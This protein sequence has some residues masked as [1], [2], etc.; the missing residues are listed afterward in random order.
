MNILIVESRYFPAVADA[1]L[2]RATL[3]LEKGGARFERFS[4]PGVLELPAAIAAAA[5][6][7]RTFEGYVALG[8]VLGLAAIPD[9]LY[10]ETVRGL[11][12]LGTQGMA[13]GNGVLLAPDE[14][15]AMGLA[16]NQ[17]AGGDAARAVLSLVVLRERLGLLS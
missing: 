17:D 3:A 14:D 15:A 10:R 9:T 2:D 7:G 5:R 12:T 11:V 16:M 4:L 1:L 8:C 13:I 6:S